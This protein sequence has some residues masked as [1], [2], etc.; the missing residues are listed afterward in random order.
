MGKVKN[1]FSN[2][3]VKN[4][5]VALL[6]VLHLL[7]FASLGLRI[8]TKHNK[9]LTVPDFTNMSVAQAKKMASS[10]D[11]VITVDDSVYVKR[12]SK[13]AIYRQNP[14]AGSKV[15]KG[16]RIAVTINAVNAKQVTM[17]NLIGYSMR[18]AKAEL[19]SRGLVLGKLMYVKDI[20]TNNVLKQLAGNMEIE[21]GTFIDSGSIINLVVGLNQDD[22]MTTVPDLLGLKYI[23]AVDGLHDNSLNLRNLRFDDTVRNYDDSLNAVVYR[24]SPASSADA[25]RMGSEVS[26]FLTLDN[27]KVPVRE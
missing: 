14:K 3:I 11:M 12:M 7:I 24:Q 6:V 15:K 8:I 1:F 17:P 5:L 19:D 18:Q 20:A 22:N 26:L 16:R 9:E 23:S 13:G 21:P 25:V 2:W 27:R 4:L 10:H